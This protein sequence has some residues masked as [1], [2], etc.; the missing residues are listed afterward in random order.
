MVHYPDPRSR[1]SV[2]TPLIPELRILRIG[3]VSLTPEFW[4]QC[5]MCS[6]YWR[7]YFSELASCE[8]HFYNGDSWTIPAQRLVAIPP[9]LDA[10]AIC[11]QTTKHVYFNCRQSWLPRPLIKQWWS[12]PRCVDLETWPV[13]RLQALG[14]HLAQDYQY[15]QDD[16]RIHALCGEIMAKLWDE[17]PNDART[18]AN[19]LHGPVPEFRSLLP[20]LEQGLAHKWTV[21][22]MA[23]ITHCSEGHLSRLFRQHLNISPMAYVIERRLCLASERLGETQDTVEHIAEQCGFDNRSYFSRSFSQH[24][25]MSPSQYR[26]VNQQPKTRYKP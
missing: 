14:D 5:H 7:I 2:Y 1:K 18:Q 12:K 15:P 16:L 4:G 22:D 17:L 25:N 24:F 11:H 19:L 13:E 21:K 10:Y 8:I 20:Q 6:P 26:R 9:W 3:A 23:A